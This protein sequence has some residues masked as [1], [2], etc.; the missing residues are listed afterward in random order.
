M[1]SPMARIIYRW[2]LACMLN[3]NVCFGVEIRRLSVPRW[4]ENGTEKSVTLDCEYVYNE[5]DIR[6]VV[7]WFFEENLEPVYQW[8]PELGVRHT[9]GI[10]RGRLDLNYTVNTVDA[11]SRYRALK[12]SEPSTELSGK[13][14]C[15]V[16]SLAG[17]DSR[18]QLMTVFVPAQTMDVKFH[19]TPN[20]LNVS[21]EATGLFPRPKL[22]LYRLLPKERTPAIVKDVSISTSNLRDTYNTSLYKTFE[23][24]EL[25]FPATTGFEC[26]VEIP[27]TNYQR[28]K[29]VAYYAGTSQM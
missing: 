7:K 26:V 1:G 29:R 21:C 15:L 24:E 6:L 23:H 4:V 12:I 28:R 10:L 14:T 27:G 22:K 25:N 19:T 13:Y 17:Q 2:L 18:E 8:I 16:T 11:Y 5:N 3:L 20:K 9:S